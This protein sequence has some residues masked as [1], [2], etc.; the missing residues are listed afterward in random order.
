MLGAIAGIVIEAMLGCSRGRAVEL[1]RGLLHTCDFLASCE[2]TWRHPAFRQLSLGL[3]VVHNKVLVR[4]ALSLPE[5]D[6]LQVLGSIDLRP[7][8]VSKVLGILREQDVQGVL[9]VAFCCLVSVCF[10]KTV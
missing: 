4:G 6:D 8:R 5:L 2:Q 10:S 1:H 9:E 3:C 7:V